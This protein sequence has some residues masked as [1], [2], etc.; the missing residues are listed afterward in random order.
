MSEYDNF[1]HFANEKELYFSWDCKPE[2]FW[3][4]LGY[5]FWILKHILIRASC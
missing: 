5:G 3:Y 4:S 2:V 1:Y